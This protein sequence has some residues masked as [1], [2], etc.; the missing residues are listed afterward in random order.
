MTVALQS[1]VLARDRLEIDHGHVAALL[2]I[3]LLIEH[4]S[5]TAG[6]TGCE[7]PPRRADDDHHAAGH[8]FAAMIPGALDHGD[9]AG[10][11]DSEALAANATEIALTGNGAIKH[12]IADNDRL[13]GHDARV[14]R[15]A[16][17][18]AATG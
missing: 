14:F 11:P 4:V 13:L 3:A 2:E 6:H 12:G 9:G 17:D 7:I 15:R 8:V 16:H 10:V 1:L 18:Q 5:D